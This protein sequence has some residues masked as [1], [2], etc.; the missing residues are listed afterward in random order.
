M[1]GLVELDRAV[2]ATNNRVVI[3]LMPPDGSFTG[4]TGRHRHAREVHVPGSIRRRAELPGEVD[5][6]VIAVGE[7]K[8]QRSPCLPCVVRRVEVRYPGAAASGVGVD[9]RDI[10]VDRADP[11]E[12]RLPRA[13]GSNAN[14]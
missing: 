7:L 14:Q 1:P 2:R 11:A 8:R 6:S 4:Q 5:A 9:D 13:V 10:V 12:P 3:L